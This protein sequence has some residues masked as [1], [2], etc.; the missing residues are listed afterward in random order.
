MRSH[1]TI[2]QLLAGK[3]IY[4]HENKGT[5]KTLRILLQIGFTEDY[6]PTHNVLRYG[7]NVIDLFTPE[8]IERETQDDLFTGTPLQRAHKDFLW[9][10][11]KINKLTNRNKVCTRGWRVCRGHVWSERYENLRDWAIQGDFERRH[12]DKK[13]V[14]PVT[15][16][17]FSMGWTLDRD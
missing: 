11:N 2:K 17:P 10:C 16:T 14:N 6:I 4:E 13:W 7:E 3:V 1:K 9:L 8:V 5:L 15:N 12:V